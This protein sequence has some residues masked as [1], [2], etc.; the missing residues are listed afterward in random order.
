[1]M[2]RCPKCDSSF[3]RLISLSTHYRNR[4]KGT[5]K[6]L[7]VGLFCND[8]EPTCGCGCGGSVRFTSI[9]Q[10]FCKY[11]K[12]HMQ[13]V[14]NNWG[15]NKKAM[16][17][18]QA[19]RREMHKRGEIKYWMQGKTVKTDSRVAELGRKISESWTDE[20]RKEYSERM[21]RNRLSG[22]IPTLTGSNHPQW[23]GGTSSIGQLARGSHR[24]YQEWKFPILKSA[25]FQC[26]RCESKNNLHVHHSQETMSEIIDQYVK[27]INPKLLDDFEIKRQ[28]V[29]S[30]IDHHLKESIPAEVLCESCHGTEHPSLNF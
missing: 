6:E 23:K 17:K 22:V 21:K 7:Y 19:T 3:E 30:V 18:S 13:R 28:I 15:H 9:T 27:E 16:E 25:N 29:E 12:G 4:H 24:L 10:G 11:R 20:K 5:S 1:M 26:E 8:I 2:N 14:Q